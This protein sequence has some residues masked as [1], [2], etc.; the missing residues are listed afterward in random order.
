MLIFV[1][2]NKKVYMPPKEDIFQRYLREFSKHGKLLEIDLG[3]A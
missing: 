3:D 1:G 2:S